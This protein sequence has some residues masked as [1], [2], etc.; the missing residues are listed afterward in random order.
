MKERAEPVNDDW[1]IIVDDEDDAPPPPPDERLDSRRIRAVM[2]E[3][4]AADAARL[5]RLVI[6]PVCAAVALAAGVQAAIAW[7]GR[8]TF[9]LACA[10]VACAATAIGVRFLARRRG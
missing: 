1:H 7:R 8:P 4:R 6:G 10:L 3:R 5:R 9:A 2:L